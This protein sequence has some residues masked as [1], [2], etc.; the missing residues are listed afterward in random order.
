MYT[1]SA[2][3]ETLSDRRDT[4]LIRGTEFHLNPRAQLEIRM[5]PPKRLLREHNSFPFNR[6][7]STAD[8]LSPRPM[9][10]VHRVVLA[11]L[12]LHSQEQYMQKVPPW[13]LPRQR[14]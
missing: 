3:T 12:R 13:R 4:S 5:N 7:Y 6:T 11:V 1:I 9:Q 8:C 2:I 14:K 10:D